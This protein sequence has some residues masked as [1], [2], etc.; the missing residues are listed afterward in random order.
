ME[1]GS[2]LGRCRQTSTVKTD[3]EGGETPADCRFVP[4]AW[5]NDRDCPCLVQLEDRWDHGTGGGGWRRAARGGD[6][7]RP[8]QYKADHEGGETPADCLFVSNAWWNDRDCPCLVTSSRTAVS[9][10][11]GAEDGNCGPRARD[12]ARAVPV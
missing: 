4:N 8:R 9:M 10:A 1:T 2:T 5:W 6:A 12:Q 7:G 11:R 3:H